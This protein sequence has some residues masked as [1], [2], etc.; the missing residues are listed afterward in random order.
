VGP[1]SGQGWWR[2]V[3]LLQHNI[4]VSTT[5]V[6]WQLGNVLHTL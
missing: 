6:A 4:Q 5:V 3:E 1:I 2:G